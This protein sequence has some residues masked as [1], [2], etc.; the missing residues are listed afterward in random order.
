M[1]V[2]LN[3]TFAS[4][5]KWRL[6]FNVENIKVC[7]IGNKSLEMQYNMGGRKPSDRPT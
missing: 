6:K 2:D 4:P 1:Q 3:E 5:E 7:T